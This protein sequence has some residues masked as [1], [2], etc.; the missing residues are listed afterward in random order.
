[1]NPLMTFDIPCGLVVL[2]LGVRHPICAVRERVVLH[3]GFVHLD[4]V[5]ALG[6]LWDVV[7]TLLVDGNRVDKVV[8]EVAVRMQGKGTIR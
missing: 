6:V 1:M 8:V 2:A 5:T 7:T 4:G 3:A